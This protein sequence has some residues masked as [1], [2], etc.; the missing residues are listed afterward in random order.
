MPETP[1][2]HYLPAASPGSP[3]ISSPMSNSPLILPTNDADYGL[4]H[5]YR[6]DEWTFNVPNNR[7]ENELFQSLNVDRTRFENLLRSWNYTPSEDLSGANSLVTSSSELSPRAV[8]T[9][10]NYGSQIRQ[11]SRSV[12]QHSGTKEYTSSTGNPQGPSTK[13]VSTAESYFYILY[14]S[15]IFI[16]TFIPFLC[17]TIVTECYKFIKRPVKKFWLHL[18]YVEI[19]NIHP[20]HGGRNRGYS[21]ASNRSSNRY[22]YNSVGS[23]SE[24][25]NYASPFT[26]SPDAREEYLQKQQGKNKRVFRFPRLYFWL[27]QITL[28][29][30]FWTQWILTFI[31]YLQGIVIVG[32]CVFPGVIWVWWRYVYGGR[33]LIGGGPQGKSFSSGSTGENNSYKNFRYTETFQYGKHSRNVLEVFYPLN[34]TEK[35]LQNPNYKLPLVIVVTGGAWTIGHRY[36]CA[37]LSGHLAESGKVVSISIDYRNF[38]FATFREMVDDVLQALRWV[39]QNIPNSNN[40]SCCSNASLKQQQVGGGGGDHSA[41]AGSTHQL[42]HKPKL[43]PIIDPN[44]I[45]LC[46]QSAGAHLAL[47]ALLGT[48]EFKF[49]NFFGWSGVYD[50]PGLQD[51]LAKAAIPAEIIQMFAGVEEKIEEHSPL[52]LLARHPLLFER[53]PRRRI[54]LFHGIHDVTSPNEQSVYLAELLRH[55]LRENHLTNLSYV[56]QNLTASSPNLVKS[57][58]PEELSPGGDTGGSKFLDETDDSKFN[59]S[60]GALGGSTSHSM[61]SLNPRKVDLILSDTY[62]THTKTVVEY[63]LRGEDPVAK[64]VLLLAGVSKQEVDKLRFTRCTYFQTDCALNIAS[65]CTPF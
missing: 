55:R 12:G 9:Q 60:A 56:S 38:P 27:I 31:R 63:P 24:D 7:Y 64:Q 22:S 17:R 28:N 44:E 54:R 50:L 46:G 8:N 30:L 48:D 18:F 51:H 21:T 36:W 6:G 58:D 19:A 40:P 52:Q 1:R 15:V 23:V 3:Q 57:E 41:A 62:D 4:I 39:K 43:L 61:V 35:D 34:L 49:A 16:V 47:L 32:I 65:R 10:M 5:V 13:K 14:S 37:A 45:T 11:V 25:S 20:Q 26:N 29:P 59:S 42:D 33:K 2:R 53:L